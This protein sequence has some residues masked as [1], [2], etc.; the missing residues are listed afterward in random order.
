MCQ[1]LFITGITLERYRE[2]LDKTCLIYDCEDKAR[3]GVNIVHVMAHIYKKK[4]H[5]P[6]YVRY[7]CTDKKKRMLMIRELQ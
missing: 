7:E 2:D 5:R 6:I 3:E 1:L 4:Y